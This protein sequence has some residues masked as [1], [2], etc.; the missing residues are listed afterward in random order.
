[1][2]TEIDVSR[3]E[4]VSATVLASLLTATR[5]YGHAPKRS[6]ME[7]SNLPFPLFDDYFQYMLSN[8]FVQMKETPYENLYYLTE[9]GH[10]TLNNF[11]RS[12]LN[13]F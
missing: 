5:N 7:S 13:P 4:W 8:G 10:K 6:I 9:K 1:M 2:T 3:K 11:E 12:I